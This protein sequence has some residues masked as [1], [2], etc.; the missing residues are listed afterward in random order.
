MVVNE[1]LRLGLTPRLLT[2]CARMMVP[3]MLIEC[4]VSAGLLLA[5]FPASYRPLP[6]NAPPLASLRLWGSQA[7]SRAD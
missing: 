1:L 2:L 7:H 3:L 4:L 6:L 5:L